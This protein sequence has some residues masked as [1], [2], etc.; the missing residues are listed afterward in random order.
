MVI[1]GIDASSSCT[2]L[3]IFNDSE[4]IYYNK[5]KPQKKQDFKANACQIVEQITPIINDYC[6]DIIYMEDVPRYVGGKGNNALVALGAV[7]GIF[8]HELSHNL[9]YNIGY[10][11][12]NEWRKKLDFL[13][14]ERKREKQK[15]KAVEF[16]NRTFGLELQ[17]A[18]GKHLVSN[19]DD[20]AE[21]I[22]IAIS[23]MI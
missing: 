8:Y 1:C 3:C 2:G 14:G 17:Y 23:Q 11:D 13:K 19:D 5:F 15:A 20:I 18:E 6:P 4:L 9:G 10:V 22:C 12:V 16:A 21:A 7:Q